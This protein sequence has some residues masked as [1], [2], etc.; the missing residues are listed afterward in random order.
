[1]GKDSERIKFLMSRLATYLTLY[2]NTYSPSLSATY[3]F[4]NDSIKM[5]YFRLYPK[6]GQEYD[7]DSAII[8]TQTIEGI[9]AA[10]DILFLE[11]NRLNRNGSITSLREHFRREVFSISLDFLR[12][13]KPQ[14]R[15]YIDLFR[16]HGQCILS[17][18]DNWED[19]VL[20]D[21]MFRDDEEIERILD[22]EFNF[23]QLNRQ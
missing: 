22:Q 23:I 7:D 14:Y 3:R 8:S 12:L 19:P 21:I 6:N 10:D 9:K 20:K 18:M 1:M 17:Y 2:A 16:F 11:L 5:F 4:V 13:V 15:S